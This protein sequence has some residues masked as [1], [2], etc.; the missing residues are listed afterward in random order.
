MV[1][2]TIAS[3]DRNI[4]S[5]FLVIPGIMLIIGVFI[6]PYPLPDIATTLIQI[7]MFLGLILLGVG[8]V[9]KK[10]E[11]ARKSKITGWVIFAFYWSTQPNA[12]YYEEGGDIFNASLCIIGVF[13]LFYI[14]YHEWLSLKRRDNIG[15]LSWIAG[16]TAIAG[17][18]YFGIERTFLAPWMIEIVAAQSTWIANL[19]IGN[20]EVHGVNI[21][22]NG[23]YTV[24]I[25]F[26]C[27]A[28]QSI[29]LFIGMIVALTKV[30][31]K[32]KATGLMVTV[33]PVYILNLFRNA[34][35]TY[36]LG[37]SLTDFNIAHNLIAK[38]GALLSLIIILFIV[39]K[40]LPEIIDEIIC[41]TD[42]PK[43]NGPLE[44]Y[45]RKIIREKKKDRS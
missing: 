16:A 20:T 3:R 28:L 7:P 9:S 27:T 40:V 30:G 44:K 13:V 23:E 25:I 42:L 19:V 14:A 5:L 21:F 37:E 35:I 45:M 26:A 2:T 31:W 38:A 43:R 1:D 18:I 4:A 11:F 10:G 36:L 24:T 22:Y 8:F 34:L 29:V 17:I 12:L 6:Y 39:A 33:I 32:R 41:L 15:C